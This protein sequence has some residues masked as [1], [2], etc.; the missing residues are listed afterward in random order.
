MFDFILGNELLSG[1]IAFGLVLIPAVIIHELGH[2]LAAKAVGITILEF[3]VGMPPRAVRL[4]RYAGTDY[5]LNWLPLG[6]F[7]RPLGEGIVSQHGDDETNTD[8]QEALDRGIK[9]PKSVFE[10][11]PLPRI[12]FMAAG[13]LANFL[14]AFVLLV[15]VALLGLPE[16][17]GGRSVLVYVSPDSA[18]GQAGVQSGD[19]V[20]RVNG[21]TF[22][23]SAA[24]AEL[25][26]GADAP[27]ELT[28]LRPSDSEPQT[29]TVTVEPNLS[30][31]G[32]SETSQ[33][34]VIAGI[35]EESPAASAGLQ[36]G[37]L[38]LALNGEPL[39]SF[40]QLQ[41]GV[42]ANLGQEILLTIFREGEEREVSLVPRANPPEGQGAM[43]VSFAADTTATRD[44]TAGLVYVDGA[45]QVDYV[46]QP[47]SVA[48]PYAWDQLVFVFNTIISLPGQLM[49]GSADPNALRP[50]GPVGVSQLGSE[51]LRQSVENDRPAQILQFIALVSLSLGLTNL[52]P[53]PA[54]DGGRILFVL[55]EILR[56]KP[57]AP[58]RE[59]MVHLVGLALLLSLMVVVTFFDIAN[60]IMNSLR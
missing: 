34:P 26:Y 43:G 35:S 40:E 12:F 28:L 6:G 8:R 2:F 27:L 24:L 37:D 31:A 45:P 49:A 44:A 5:T 56:G 3:G 21:V 9:N 10:T 54:L 14:M 38:L 17:V 20:E 25:L 39:E 36:V 47:L 1:L 15:A 51:A 50:V 4:F 23:D 30:G 29:L 18:L 59:G 46:A 57:I 58:E 53:I 11:K 41:T 60:P 48:L 7:V 33:H 42:R 55:I 32:A 19:L 13:S 16:V 22:A 52:L